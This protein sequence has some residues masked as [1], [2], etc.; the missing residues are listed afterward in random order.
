MSVLERVNQLLHAK[1]DEHLECKEAK[2]RFDFEKLVNYCAALANEGGGQMLLGVTDKPPRRVVGTQAFMEL[3]RTKAGLIERLRLRIEANDISHPD[4]RVILFDIPA[5]PLG[6]P[7]SYKGAY[8]MRGG[9]DLAPMTP[10]RLKQIF[11]ETGPD[12]SAE[13]CAK[14]VL[15]DLD[16]ESIDRFRT[17]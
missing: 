5:R 12:Y 15:T 16:A 9:E 6:M 3:E 13:I 10:D 11:D 14:A 17:A 7:I 8:W 2:N 4:G 1:E